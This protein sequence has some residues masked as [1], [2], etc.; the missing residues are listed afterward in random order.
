MKY[1][2]ALLLTV[3]IPLLASEQDPRLAKL[4]RANDVDGTM[5]VKELTSGQLW[6]H[7]LERAQTPYSPASSFKVLNSLIAMQQGLV[8][9]P[10]ATLFTWDKQPKRFRA[11][12]QDHSLATAFKVSCVW[13]YQQIAAQVGESVYDSTL[14]EVG[15]GKLAQPYALTQFWLDGSL[16][17]SALGQIEFLEKLY[18][19]QLPFE[20]RH[21][22]TLQQVML[23]E[24]TDAYRLYGKTGWTGLENIKPAG[25]FVGY[26]E[27]AQQ[28][29][30][31]ATN[32]DLKDGDDL[33]LRQKITK[34]GLV[35]LGAL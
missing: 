19:R 26:V 35:A 29:W 13:C 23:I 9:D 10:T 1:L 30:L 31:F 32:L 22:D 24:Q 20:A 21:F 28:V 18:R 4:F 5:V 16:T 7:N 8:N 14:A 12:N 2:L 15:Y 3:S 33:K 17:I 34:E 27:Q 25:W 6:L 11:W